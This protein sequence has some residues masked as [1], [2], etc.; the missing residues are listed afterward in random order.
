MALPWDLDLE[1]A[2]RRVRLAWRLAASGS[3]PTAAVRA[4]E[5]WLA[6]SAPEPVVRASSNGGA[7]ADIAEAVVL[8]P[9]NH[10]RLPLALEALAWAAAL[11]RLA[12]LLPGEL[13][14]RL[15]NRLIAIARQRPETIGEPLSR[16][17]LTA[18]LP[19]TLA[20]LLGEL[21]AARG[22]ARTGRQ[23][24]AEG[25]REVV[26]EKGLVHPPQLPILRPLVAT[27]TRSQTLAAALELRLGPSE[28]KRFRRC[29]EQALR[30][31]RADGRPAFAPL[32]AR[33][34]DPWWIE[35]AVR[36][37]DDRGATK[38]LARLV[39]KGLSRARTGRQKRRV[40]PSL[41]NEGASLA[42]L[43]SNW[44]SNA[45]R[46][47]VVY[48]E[49]VRT[50]L[51]V[52]ATCLWA[53]SWEVEVRV[54]GHV[55][56]PVRQWEQVC[57]ESDDDIDYLEL[58]LKLADEVTVERHIALARNDNVLVLADAVLGIGEGRIEYRGSIVLG[59][60]ATFL[61]E[62]ETREA[63]ARRRSAPAGAGLAAGAGRV[64]ARRRVGSWR[65]RP[66]GW[67]SRNRPTARRCS[68]RCWS[69]ST[70]DGC[71]ARRPGAS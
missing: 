62:T 24:L 68:R 44:L 35:A 63:R 2:S 5:E 67:N 69:I 65:P 30:L 31:T 17:I 28:R 27:W 23:A 56:P 55:L 6:R 43:R 42:V 70:R 64:A 61:P 4:V 66:R 26:D 60:A 47:A 49:V 1:A 18:E 12:A 10:D 53:G 57:W 25:L 11:P 33:R 13:W 58:V 46:M 41:E 15:A 54:D 21:E 48:D 7:T 22:L 38:V 37:A 50:E 8:A 19:L 39:E 16:Q 3:R 59:G 20:Y 32:A 52:G 14:W 9:S 40:W 29:L 34:D 36:L 51:S 45:P 71:G